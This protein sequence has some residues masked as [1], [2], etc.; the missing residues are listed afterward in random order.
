MTKSGHPKCVYFSYHTVPPLNFSSTTPLVPSVSLVVMY[1]Y[2]LVVVR[3]RSTNVV[4]ILSEFPVGPPI[5]H[6]FLFLFGLAPTIIMSMIMYMAAFVPKAS[7]VS[8]K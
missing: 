1:A 6:P 7:P 2:D 5:F 3:L 4:P 8:M